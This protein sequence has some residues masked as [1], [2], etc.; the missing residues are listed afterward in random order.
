MARMG[1]CGKSENALASRSG[2]IVALSAPKALTDCALAQTVRAM[3][4]SVERS[5]DLWPAYRSPF[6]QQ[7]SNWCNRCSRQ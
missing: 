5:Q 2:A 1:Y 4:R 3:N 7:F 6:H